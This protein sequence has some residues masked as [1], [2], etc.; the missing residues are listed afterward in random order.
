MWQNEIEVFGLKAYHNDDWHE[1][2]DDTM[3][4]GDIYQKPK[5]APVLKSQNEMGDVITNQDGDLQFEGGNFGDEGS[6]GRKQPSMC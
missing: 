5:Q 6:A 3:Q 1:S 4:I 2:D